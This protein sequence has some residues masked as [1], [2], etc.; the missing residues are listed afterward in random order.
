MTVSLRKNPNPFKG[1]LFILLLVLTPF[2]LAG[3]SLFTSKP[4]PPAIEWDPSP[5]AVVIEA[6]SPIKQYHASL[7]PDLVR[8]YIPE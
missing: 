3:C 5:E 8:N 4:T 7:S 2:N 6:A 1:L